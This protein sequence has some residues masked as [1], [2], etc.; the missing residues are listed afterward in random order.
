MTEQFVHSVSCMM[1]GLENDGFEWLIESKNLKT[2]RNSG[3]ALSLKPENKV[4]SETS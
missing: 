4:L 1:D 3:K 2:V